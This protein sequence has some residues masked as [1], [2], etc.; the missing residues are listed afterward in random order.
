MFE[1]SGRLLDEPSAVLRA[2]FEH[3]VKLALAD[4]DVHLAPH[5]RVRKEL[6]DVEQ[7]AGRAVDRVLRSPAAEKRSGDRH[8][9]VVDRQNPVGVVDRERDLGPAES[10]TLG[11]SREDDVGHVASAEILR[12]LFSHHP[13]QRVDDVGLAGPVRADDAVDARLEPQSGGGREGFEPS[14]RQSLQVHIHT[15]R[16]I[17]KLRDLSGSPAIM[18]PPFLADLNDPILSEN[19]H[20][21][22]EHTP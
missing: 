3:F 1:D 7:P 12:S 6:L 15:I 21:K 5:A 10:R 2:C 19:P 16:H 4:D 11:R 14:E 18:H 17:G 9:R 13:G 20:V 22:C 8:F